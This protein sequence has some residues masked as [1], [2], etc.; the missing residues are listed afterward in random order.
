MR[1]P[2]GA[3]ER[4]F[5][6]PKKLKNGYKTLLEATEEDYTLGR[7][8][9]IKCRWCHD[10]FKRWKDFKRH[11]NTSKVHPLKIIICDR[12]GKFFTR[13]DALKRHRSPRE[14]WAACYFGQSPWSAE[15]GPKTKEIHKKFIEELDHHLS[16][17]DL[18]GKAF[19][20]QIDVMIMLE[21]VID[22]SCGSDEEE[23]S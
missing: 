17:G 21:D 10:S 12:C 2:D 4:R 1:L 8:R 9:E 18:L 22:E 3:E 19:Y 14:P 16:S 6:I 20:R 15:R 11:C 23:E 7:V 5:K 13:A